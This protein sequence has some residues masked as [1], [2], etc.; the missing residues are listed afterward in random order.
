VSDV[1]AY[2][3][4]ERYLIRE[5][6]WLIVTTKEWD[7][8]ETSGARK[9]PGEAAPLTFSDCLSGFLADNQKATADPQWAQ[10]NRDYILPAIGDCPVADVGLENVLAVLRPIWTTKNE[11]ARRTQSKMKRVLAWAIAHRLRD[12]YNP[13]G[14][15]ALSATLPAKADVVRV[16]HQSA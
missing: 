15:D 9:S 12:P 7:M 11:T 1:S 16:R 6:F 13:A 3:S 10:H 8:R 14:W 5:Y 2:G 4:K